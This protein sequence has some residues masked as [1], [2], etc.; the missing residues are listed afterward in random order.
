MAF[1]YGGA[2]FGPFLSDFSLWPKALFYHF[3]F[4]NALSDLFSCSIDWVF[5]FTAY[6]RL[7]QAF[8]CLLLTDNTPL[9]FP[10]FSSAHYNQPPSNFSSPSPILI[11]LPTL[12][13]SFPPSSYIF[14]RSEPSFLTPSLLPPFLHTKASI[15][16]FL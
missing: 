5:P 6:S 11:H 1:R 15:T 12:F 8:I 2:V 7:L 14:L 16:F 4:F 3:D 9:I 13:L 10:K